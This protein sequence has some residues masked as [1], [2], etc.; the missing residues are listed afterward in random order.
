[1]GIGLN[2]AKDIIEQHNG[3]ITAYNKEHCAV[4]EVKLLLSSK[5]ISESKN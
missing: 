5:N 3:E 1:M 2:I 4:F